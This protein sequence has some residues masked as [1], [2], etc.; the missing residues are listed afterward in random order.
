MDR[1]PVGKSIQV[2]MSL[3]DSPEGP[4]SVRQVARELDT[5]PATVHR[6]F[7]GFQERQLLTRDRDGSYQPGLELFRLC[8]AL[9]DNLSPVRLV[10]PHLESLAEDCGEAVLF[11]AYNATRGQML[12]LDFVQAAHQLQYM[13]ELDRWIPVH[14][15]ATGQAIL[16]FLPEEERAEI[17]RRGLDRLTGATLV[18]RIA[19]EHALATARDRGYAYTHGQRTPGAVGIAAPVFDSVGAVFGD[20]CITIPEQRFDER[21]EASLAAALMRT[22]ATVS[23]E[24]RAAGCRRG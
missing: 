10:R 20:V 3:A 23:E 18:S 1:D 7:R 21:L 24:L 5:S 8:Q 17:Y 15:G 19:L 13:V 22:S 4:W 12:F 16:A 6:I 9:A 2:L 11:G 14:S